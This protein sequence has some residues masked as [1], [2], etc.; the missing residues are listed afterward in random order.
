MQR[1]SRKS[2]GQSNSSKLPLGK[3]NKSAASSGFGKDSL[4]SARWPQRFERASL[5]EGL[6]VFQWLQTMV[7]PAR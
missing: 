2:L 5:Q 6:C 4:N 3:A 7:K 1:P